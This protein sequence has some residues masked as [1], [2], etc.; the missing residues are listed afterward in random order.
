MT[1]QLHGILFAY[2]DNPH[3][4]ELTSHRTVASIPFGGRYRVIDF[5]LSNMVN[6]GIIDIGVVMQEKCQSL[7]DHLGSG[8]DWDLARKRG[9]LRVLPPFHSN[10]HQFRG[11][12]EA[13]YGVYSYMEDIRQDYV[14]MADADVAC[15]IDLNE[16]FQAHLASG[17]DITAVC[18]KNM[19]GDPRLSTY[20]KLDETGR[21]RDVLDCPNTPEGYE[22]LKVYILSTK[23]LVELV[24]YCAAHNL[25]SFSVDVLLAMKDQLHIQS[26][27]FD[28]YVA[29]LT[30][31]ASYYNRSMDLLQESV[32]TDLFSMDH[33][34]RT[35]DRS[36]P[37]TYYAPG[38]KSVN[39]LVA[40]GCIIE[41]TVED[42]VIFRG[43]HVGKDAV[44]KHCVLMQDTVIEEGA[45]IRYVV[46]DKDV[47]I[48]AHRR[49]AGHASYPLAIDKGSII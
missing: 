44:V 23:K 28:G 31:V 13:L 9:G 38:S 47:T 41:G 43:V 2:R 37:S 42:C 22:S 49:L 10:N 5:M 4:R 7:L 24:D 15:N 14:V 6:A 17:A 3:L 45:N 1:T 19:S 48:K 21:V 36:D 34:I 11:K 25:Y 26:Y 33:P 32:G 30:T 12:M 20:F 16:V 29:R 39:S 8:K 40:D 46:A 35:K 27:F 18:T